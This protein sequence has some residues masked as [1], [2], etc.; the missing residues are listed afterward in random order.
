M[1]RRRLFRLAA[2]AGVATLSGPLFAQAG[3][4]PM[5]IVIGFAPG[6]SA[7]AVARLLAEQL[8]DA[9]GRPVV[10]ENK[11]GASGRLAV[12]AVKAAP[13]DGDTLLMAPHGP[14]TLFP[15]IYKSLR[16]DPSKDFTPV[17]RLT[18][19][20]YVFTVS[21]QNPARDLGTFR[22]WAKA[23][24]DA[25]GFG[26]PGVGTIPHFLGMQIA[27]GLGIRLAHVP[28]RGA[29]P[30]LVDLMGDTIAAVISPITDPLEMH[31]AGKVRILATTG[32]TPTHLLNGVP[33][34]KE[35]GVDLD[36]TAWYGLYAPAGLSTAQL[37]KLHAATNAAWQTAPVLERLGRMGLT[38]A[39]TS[40]AELAALQRRESGTW[41]QAVKA[42]GFTPED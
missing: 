22:D 32:A 8:K 10:V 28:Y 1:Q 2:G 27:R 11:T 16:F 5:R 20:D 42:S 33:T 18:V 24:S 29:A 26:S 17:T 37:Q 31:K 7:D 3:A 12:E 6:G 9:L 38:P 40:S 21:A 14:M 25:V 41:A 39:I 23:R 34:A 30:S 35:A 4:Q 19:S 36:I 15:H 13:P